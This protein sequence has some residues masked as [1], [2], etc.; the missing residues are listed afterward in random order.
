M[1][2]TADNPSRDHTGTNETNMHAT[3]KAS[4]GSSY[5][6]KLLLCVM[7]STTPRGHG[8]LCGTRPTMA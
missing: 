1:S 4:A 8:T 2:P 3:V 7:P 6:A 5:N